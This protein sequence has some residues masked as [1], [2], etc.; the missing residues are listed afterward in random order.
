MFCLSQDMERRTPIHAA[1]FRGEAEIVDLLAQSGKTYLLLETFLRLYDAPFEI[2]VQCHLLQ[3]CFDG[4]IRHNT[5]CHTHNV[6][7]M[8]QN[9]YRN[10]NYSLFLAKNCQKNIGLKLIH[11]HRNSVHRRPWLS[12]G[13]RKRAQSQAHCLQYE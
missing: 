13:Y 3:R 1:A 5:Q 4:L 12:M 6:W 10:N 9:V 2:S 11:A 7:T 8:T